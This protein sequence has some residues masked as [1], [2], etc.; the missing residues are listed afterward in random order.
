MAKDLNAPSEGERFG[1]SPHLATYLIVI[2]KT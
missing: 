2:F 1:S